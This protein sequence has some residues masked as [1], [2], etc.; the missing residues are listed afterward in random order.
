MTRFL[1][2]YEHFLENDLS[3]VKLIDDEHFWYAGKILNIELVETINIKYQYVARKYFNYML[4]DSSKFYKFTQLFQTERKYIKETDLKD[5]YSECF[6][7]GKGQGDRPYVHLHEAL[8]NDIQNNKVD[9]IRKIWDSKSGIVV[10]KFFHGSSSF[11]ASTKEAILIDFLELN[12]LTNVRRGT[13]YGGIDKWNKKT[14]MNKNMGT[15][16]G[17]NQPSPFQF[18]KV[19]LNNNLR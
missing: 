13:Y 5:F 12:E 18:S 10:L 17:P 3:E 16:M 7:V 19:F 14:L 6:Y 8:D 9:T 1:G 15:T 11:V 4:F 2:A